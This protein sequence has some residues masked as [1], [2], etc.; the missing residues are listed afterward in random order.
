MIFQPTPFTSRLWSL[1]PL[2]PLFLP[3]LSSPSLD[4]FILP[5]LTFPLLVLSSPLLPLPL[6]LSL[7]LPQL[8]LVRE[9]AAYD[10]FLSYRV[11]SDAHHAEKL[12]NMLTERYVRTSIHVQAL[13]HCIVFH[14]LQSPYCIVDS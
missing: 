14:F 10:V 4:Q 6:T 7:L 1:I 3:L 13:V 12:Y 8:H 11:N 5:Q 9:H 2:L